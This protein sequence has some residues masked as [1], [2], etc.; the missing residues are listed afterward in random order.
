MCS[1]KTRVLESS[2]SGLSELRAALSAIAFG[3]EVSRPA[4]P[5]ATGEG[6]GTSVE[7]PRTIANARASDDKGTVNLERRA[8]R[9]PEP[10]E[11]HSEERVVAAPFPAPCLYAYIAACDQ[12]Y[13]AFPQFV[14]GQEVTLRHSLSP[15]CQETVREQTDV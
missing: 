7:E 10:K 11:H 3:Q 13:I 5:N 2:Q 12:P 9:M 15:K 4:H 6:D 8:T 1:F 14:D